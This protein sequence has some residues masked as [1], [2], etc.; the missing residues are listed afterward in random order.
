MTLRTVMFNAI[1]I[2]VIQGFTLGLYLYIYPMTLI[3]AFGGYEQSNARFLLGA[4]FAFGIMLEA[5][6]EL[7]LGAYGDI[8][9]Y[10][11]TLAFSFFFRALYFVGFLFLVR[12]KGMTTLAPLIGFATIALFSISYTFWSGTNSAWFYESLKAVGAEERHE[13]LLSIILIYYYSTFIAGSVLSAWLYFNLKEGNNEYIYRTGEYIIYTIGAIICCLG[14]IFCKFIVTE[15]RKFF[16]RSY[17][18]ELGI[19]LSEAYKYC[20]KT[21][22]IFLLIQISAFFT[23]LIYV[24]DYLW[25]TYAK[26]VLKVENLDFKWL[27][28]LLVMT[29]GNLL[30]NVIIVR[31]HGKRNENEG[32]SQWRRLFIACLGFSLPIAILSLLAIINKDLFPI[33]L[34]L[35]AIGKI[36][37]GGKEAPFDALLNRSITSAKS[38]DMKRNPDQTRA[39]I[40]SAATIFN[41]VVVLLFFVPTTV[42]GEENTV[43]GWI[44]PSI[45]LAIVVLLT[46]KKV[47]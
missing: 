16:P 1:I 10:K 21:K 3:D 17:V 39:T 26:D 37:E 24:T 27:S 23:L 42:L 29:L 20:L 40:L 32:A 35:V 45:L 6:L 44:I 5:F 34:S 38:E 4:V 41:A 2:R 30:G 25:P 33:F 12:F 13:K 22:N 31:I 14:A 36:A 47:K 15:P 28:I 9:G 43:Q 19:V 46:R 7:P 11:P 18:A 8:R